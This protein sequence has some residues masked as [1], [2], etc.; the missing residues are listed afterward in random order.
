MHLLVNELCVQSHML[1]TVLLSTYLS[2]PCM[3][4]CLGGEECDLVNELKCSPLSSMV[5]NFAIT[6]SLHIKKNLFHHTK[7][8]AVLLLCHHKNIISFVSITI[9]IFQNTVFY[10]VSV[11]TLEVCTYFMMTGI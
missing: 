2:N 6:A 7:V 1:I 9:K 5:Y 3:L 10:G 8:T 11:L 4:H